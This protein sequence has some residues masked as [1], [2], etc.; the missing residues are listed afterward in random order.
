MLSDSVVEAPAPVKSRKTE[1]LA[2]SPDEVAAISGDAALRDLLT[3][4]RLTRVSKG[5][6][7]CSVIAGM[8]AT[9]L[10]E[11]CT[12]AGCPK[13]LPVCEESEVAAAVTQ[14]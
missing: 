14:E 1:V 13:T 6:H 5:Y 9:F 7:V 11:C 10:P 8:V 2:A 12:D 4:F 3:D